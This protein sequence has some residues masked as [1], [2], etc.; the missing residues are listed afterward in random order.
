MENT[1]NNIK[2]QL[3]TKKGSL[4]SRYKKV[5]TSFLRGNKIHMCWRN[6]GRNLDRSSYDAALDF[7]TI[8]GC[9]YN[10]GN[11]ARYG[12]MNG[13]FVMLTEEQIKKANEILTTLGID[14]NYYINF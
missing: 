5:I 10:T 1:I 4:K 13:Y 2:S 7:A 6:K 3:F 9:G 14:I 12:G 11:D 8:I